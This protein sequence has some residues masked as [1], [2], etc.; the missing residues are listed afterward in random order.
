MFYYGVSAALE[1]LPE[2]QPVTLRG[3]IGELCAIAQNTGYNALELHVRDPKRYDPKEIRETARSHGL[4]IC[5][6]ANGME[7]SVGGLSLIDRENDKREAAVQRLLEHVDF[8]AELDARLIVGIMRGNIPRGETARPYIE[9]FGEALGRICAYAGQKR[10]SVVLEAINRYINNYLNTLSETIDFIGSL[11][12]ENLSLHLDTHSMAIEEKNLKD[13][14]L[15]CRGKPL[16]YVHYS[17]NN[18]LYPG[19]GALDFRELTG[20]LMDIGYTGYITLECLPFPGAEESAR[21]G[22]SYMKS[23]EQIVSIERQCR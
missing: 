10:V 12:C 22:L 18:R 21:R 7:Y 20:A 14:V 6:T 23:I 1:K 5:A 9:R 19:G 17:D 4:S 2:S 15:Y 13:A 11:G 16:G 3:S 8:A